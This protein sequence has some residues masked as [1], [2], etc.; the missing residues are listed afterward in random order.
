MCGR[1]FRM[2]LSFKYHDFLG[3]PSTP[4]FFRCALFPILMFSGTPRYPHFF[5]T[6][7]LSSKIMIFRNVRVPPIF[8]NVPLFRISFFRSISRMFGQGFERPAEI[9]NGRPRFR[10]DG[11]NFERPAEISNVWPR[12][13]T[14]G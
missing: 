4:G 13:R 10:T 14:S 9:S 11:Q 5:H 8:S 1:F 2:F 7:R 12:S 6:S 3:F